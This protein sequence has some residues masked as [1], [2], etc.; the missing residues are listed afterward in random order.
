MIE[1]LISK[2]IIEKMIG[3]LKESEHFT[4]GI[5][6]ILESVDLTNKGAVKKALSRE[7]QDKKNEGT[8]S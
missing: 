7:K 2:Q 1:K 5:L 6:T 8:E 3:N 4:E